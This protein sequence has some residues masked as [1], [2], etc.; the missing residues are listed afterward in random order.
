MGLIMAKQSK[1][2]SPDINE[3][4]RYGRKMSKTEDKI[5]EFECDLKL[6]QDMF[7]MSAVGAVKSDNNELIALLSDGDSED[8][9]LL[10][11]YLPMPMVE[12]LTD[13][14][15]IQMEFD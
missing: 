15:Q 3:M 8:G 5:R 10:R 12:I 7:N 4:I 1:I 6:G 2:K 13:S 9:K 11:K 14:N